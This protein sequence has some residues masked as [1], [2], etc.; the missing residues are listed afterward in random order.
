M[1][2]KV[3]VAKKTHER[4]NC[5]DFHWGLLQATEGTRGQHCHPQ[6]ED[7]KSILCRGFFHCRYRESDGKKGF[8]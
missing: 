8:K 2:T 7:N 4:E 3:V 1:D 5:L 6:R